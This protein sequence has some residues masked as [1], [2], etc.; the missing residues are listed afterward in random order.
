MKITIK[1]WI[2]LLACICLFLLFPYFWTFSDKLST[3]SQDWANFGT[4]I[5]GTLGPIGAFLAFWGLIQQ[6]KIYRKNA[7]IE[8]L[9]AKL[10]SIDNDIIT[11][12]RSC[13]LDSNGVK[14]ELDLGL[15]ISANPDPVNLEGLIHFDDYTA[16]ILVQEKQ[17]EYLRS[18]IASNG[19]HQKQI[20][21][22]YLSA[23]EEKFKL[24]NFYLKAT[25]MIDS[26]TLEV[27]HYNEKY[28][29]LL[30]EMHK[31]QWIDFDIFTV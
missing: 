9:N 22:R 1:T 14:A 8:R 10:I 4:Y 29:F 25:N 6:N 28:K 3:D 23:L 12:A 24:I 11:I 16:K 18:K 17:T 15:I 21:Y 30:K 2:T 7:E 13:Y 20:N 26:D 31:K 19:S 5:G 27:L